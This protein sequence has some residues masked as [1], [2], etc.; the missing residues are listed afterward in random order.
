M[1][2][3]CKKVLEKFDTWK[4][5]G[6]WSIKT[7]IKDDSK[8]GA[9]EQKYTFVFSIGSPIKDE[10]FLSYK[11]GGIYFELQSHSVRGNYTVS[12]CSSL[13]TFDDIVLEVY[14]NVWGENVS[15]QSSLSQIKCPIWR[16]LFLDKGF[17]DV[18]TKTVY[19]LK[20][21]NSL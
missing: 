16:D 21:P 17:L 8:Y 4:L 19:L 13:S 18:E 9:A 6:K 5:N 7:N 1:N 2:L 11:E 15:V 3:H 20:N 12:L 14:K 10:F